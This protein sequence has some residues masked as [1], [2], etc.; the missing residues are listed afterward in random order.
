MAWTFGDTY[1]GKQERF[2]ER[3]SIVGGFVTRSQRNSASVI[4]AMHS[5]RW[6]GRS[7]WLKHVET[8]EIDR[9]ST[10][11]STSSLPGSSTSWRK[12]R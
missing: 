6:V 10:G 1:S 4:A 11:Q 12:V 3:S 2:E 8:T 7:L 5:G 9:Q